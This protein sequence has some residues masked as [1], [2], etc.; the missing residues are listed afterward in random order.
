MHDHIITSPSD[1]FSECFD[2]QQNAA[3]G[4]LP[5]KLAAMLGIEK[6]C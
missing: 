3:D 4:I 1:N 6:V 5:Q 2:F